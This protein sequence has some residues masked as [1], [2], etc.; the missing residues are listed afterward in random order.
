[1]K[2]WVVEIF[3]RSEP[4]VTVYTISKKAKNGGYVVSVRGSNKF[5]PKAHGRYFHDSEESVQA[6]I[7]RWAE[8]ELMTAD[9]RMKRMQKLLNGS[10]KIEISV[11]PDT[12]PVPRKKVV[13]D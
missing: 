12:Q 2:V 10:E 4:S 1:M 6:Y 5:I 13:A 8:A 9:R 11:V 7:A 3:G